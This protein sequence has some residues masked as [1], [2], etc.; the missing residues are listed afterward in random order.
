MGD[1]YASKFLLIP[2]AA[3]AVFAPQG[4][5]GKLAR[6]SGVERAS[7]E[8]ERPTEE[9]PPVGGV[10]AQRTPEERSRELYKSRLDFLE[11]SVKPVLEATLQIQG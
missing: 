4:L 3:G 10:D 6:L 2:A 9:S 7:N 5:R 11:H 8:Q 1:I